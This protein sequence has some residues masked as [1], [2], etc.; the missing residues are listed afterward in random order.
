MNEETK[1]NETP[2]GRSRDNSFHSTII[3]IRKDI[4]NFNFYDVSFISLTNVVMVPIYTHL[5]N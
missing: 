3:P 4:E 1:E 2:K 5:N